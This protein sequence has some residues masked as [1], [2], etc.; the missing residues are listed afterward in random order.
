MFIISSYK[1][2]ASVELMPFGEINF[3]LIEP[4]SDYFRVVPADSSKSSLQTKTWISYDKKSLY[5]HTFCDIDDTFKIGTYSNKETLID[6]DFLRYQIITDADKHYSYVFYAFPLGNKLDAI[7]NPDFSYNNNWNSNY[8]YQSQ[9]DENKWVTTTKIPFANLRFSGTSPWNW[10]IIFTRKLFEDNYYYSL[11]F[12]TTKMG[13]DYYEKA[14]DIQINANISKP[15]IV[16]FRPYTLFNYDILDKYIEIDE[17]NF[18]VDFLIEPNFK[19][20]LKLS[21]NPDFSDV[22]LDDEINSYNSKYAPSYEENRF[23]FIED[24]NTLGVNEQ[25][26]YSRHIVK[27]LYAIKLTSV[28]ENFSFGL[29]STK[30][31]SKTTGYTDDYFNIVALNPYLEYGDVQLS[32]LNR[33]NEDYHNEVLHLV[34]N[35]YLSKRSNAW[36][37]LNFSLLS[38]FEKDNSKT[39]FWGKIGFDSYLGN[40]LINTTLENMTKNYCMD[41]GRIYED[42]FFGWHSSIDYDIDLV[43]RHLSSFNF[44]LYLGEEY[45]NDNK[46]LLERIAKLNT[47]FTF[48]N[49]RLSPNLMYVKEFYN[50]NYFE[51]NRFGVGLLYSEF[52]SFQPS[53]AYYHIQDIIYYDAVTEYQH[54]LQA[55]LSGDINKF[56]SYYL[57]LYYIN[58]YQYERTSYQDDE[59]LIFNG[60]LVINF[61]NSANITSGVRFNNFQY[62]GFSDHWGFYSNLNLEYTPNSFFTLGY[63]NMIDEYNNQFEDTSKS[64]YLKLS[65]QF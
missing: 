35:L 24:V 22:P 64:L 37:D 5:I 48:N 57:T 29:L 4:F 51:K 8:S 10:K 11:P 14:F 25:L 15:K 43:D 6:A 53:I 54:Y 41:M 52:S 36:L 13:K 34:P 62:E 45:D 30:D 7:R 12:V 31:N 46:N 63:K 61:S 40:F 18:G 27:P 17:N 39:G 32:F 21:I 50:D 65:Y 3:D 28:N 56:V 58:Y 2:I 23:F 19:T 44:S 49:L 16:S 33:I 59:Y 1:H 20:K 60:D 26:F 38:D 42:N 47:N 9:F 55:A